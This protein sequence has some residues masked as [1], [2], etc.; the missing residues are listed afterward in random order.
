MVEYPDGTPATES[1]MA[2]DVAVFLTWASEP[3]HDD[4]KR[5]GLKWIL[6][7][8]AAAALS[9]YYKRWRWSPLKNRRVTYTND[10]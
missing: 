8:A 7:I 10:V 1:Q 2:K 6:A 9:G 4:R 5:V 3:E